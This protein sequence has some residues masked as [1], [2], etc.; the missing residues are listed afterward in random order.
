MSVDFP[1]PEGPMIETKSPRSISNEILLST[2]SGHFAEPVIFDQILDLDDGRHECSLR[3]LAL[4][5]RQRLGN[6]LTQAPF[7]LAP[8]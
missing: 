5:R 7:Y 3:T 2:C 6:F 4:C 8:R 1:D